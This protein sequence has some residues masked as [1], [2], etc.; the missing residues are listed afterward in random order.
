MSKSAP[1]AKTRILLTDTPAT[2]KGKIKAA[3]TDSYKGI[4]YDPSSRPGT[5]NL[6]EIYAHMTGRDDFDKIAEEFEAAGTGKQG[7]K[8]KVS[9][10]VIE[11]LEVVRKEYGRIIGEV[12]Y[13]KVVAK[14]GEEKAQ[15]SA[16][17]T[18]QRVKRAVGLI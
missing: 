4:E 10:A 7:L 14:I 9:D 18:L 5:S 8:D 17:R 11:G 15:E 1:D 16:A 12:G 6:I 2:I 13:L 3:M